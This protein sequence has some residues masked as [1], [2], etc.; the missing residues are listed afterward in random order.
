MWLLPI[1]VAGAALVIYLASGRYASTDN[2]YVKG[3]RVQ[4]AAEVSG[5]IIDIDVVENQRVRQGDLLLQIDPRPYRIALNRA[6]A[7]LQGARQEIES[8][9]ASYRQ[10]QE[11]I[12]LAHSQEVFALAEY[13]R[14]SELAAKRVGTQRSAEETRRDLEV[15]SQR[16]AMLNEELTRIVVGLANDPNIALI[17]HPRV[18]QAM[19]ARDEAALNLQRCEVRAPIDGIVARKPSI[20]MF[21]APGVPLL[22]VVADTGLWIEANFKETDLTRVRAGQP[23]T[24]RID[25]YPDREW[26]GTVNSISQASGA[27][28]ALLPPQ[29]AS[30]NW[31]KVVQRIPVRI[32]VPVRPDDPPLRTGMSATIDIDTGHV[33]RLADVWQP[34][35]S[36]FRWDGAAA[37]GTPPARK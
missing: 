36:L 11:E 18:R 33:R 32:D 35:A 29:N 5:P 22:A 20:G 15:A 13:Q 27:E 4:V 37:A 19:A 3:E 24:I 30:G 21:A 25:T 23:V 17:S 1:V 26:H 6:E 7:E 10:K 31:V 14:Q 2:A 16:I 28:F 8:L 9:K 34:I 12:K